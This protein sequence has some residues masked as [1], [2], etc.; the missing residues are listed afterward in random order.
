MSHR[1]LVVPTAR[2]VGVTSACLG[3]LRALDRLG[4]SFA[5]YK[6]VA[7]ATPDRSTALVRLN[8]PLSPPDPIPGEEAE[9]LLG[10]GEEAELLER[11]VA[12]IERVGADRDV[13]VVEGLV[14]VDDVVYATA[15]NVAIARAI[16]ANLVFV[17]APHEGAA[18]DPVKLADNID[19]A[20]RAFGDRARG[21]SRCCILNRVPASKNDADHQA[22]REALLREDLHPL[23]IIPERP[24]LNAP[25]LKDVAEQLNARVVHEGDWTRR[26]VRDVALCAATV[27][28]ACKRMKSGVLVITPGDRDDVVLAAALASLEGARLAG[29]L[30][31][32]NLVPSAEVMRLC[33]RAIDD[34][35]PVLSVADDSYPTAA[36]VHDMSRQVPPD[37]HDRAE[38]IMDVVAGY[39]DTEWLGRLARAE[40]PTRMTTPAFRHQLVEAAR[41]AERHIVLP[42]GEE[43]RTVEA[44]SI[45][46]R[47]G[48]ARCTLLGDPNAIQD[49]A[50][51]RGVTLGPGVT[52]VDPKQ[53][54]EGYVAPMV[55]MRAHRGLTVPAARDQLADNVVLGT[56][57]LARGEVD[58][59]VSGAVHTTANT[60]RPALQLIRTA[61][62]SSIV[63]SVFFMCLPEQVL[64]YGDCAVNPNPTAEQ[65][66]EIALQSADSA[67]A[68]GIEPRVA[69]ISYSTG[70][71]GA[72]ADV[73]KVARATELARARRP[74][75]A[76]DGPL[77]YD[78]AAIESVGRKKAPTSPVAGQA[79]VF[80]FPDLNTGNTTY[81]AVQ[82]SANV[83]SIGPM[84]QG[85]R[86]PVNDLSRGALI[87]DIVFTIAITA[88]QGAAA[89]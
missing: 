79:T 68:F 19:I 53:V 9:R 13:V 11:I 4:L 69:M 1:L 50:R 80:V 25:R 35:L 38:R 73:D 10:L 54:R 33:R 81:K 52:I 75:L 62:G 83:V 20:S 61:E 60:I 40:R 37:D 28:L 39:L 55:A 78:A 65:L 31:T 21:P 30:L 48:I 49:V 41:A 67:K 23:G 85:L 6:P 88:V 74:E 32:C 18:D 29:L 14:P 26:R 22:L 34:G 57:M 63:S 46:A 12:E 76:I 44:A 8:T 36:H 77:Q 89:R 84:L 58:G 2:R 70:T 16:D 82:R 24:M 87:D 72:G 56:M 47:R 51:R 59:L 5:F 64:V 66:A 42:E 71:S 43:P 15:L 17:A 27:G 86:L 7:R 45:A 3:L